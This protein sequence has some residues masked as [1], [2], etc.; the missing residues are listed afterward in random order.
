MIRIIPR[1]DIKGPNLVKG[2]QF[3]GHRV[4]GVAW[5]FARRYYEEGADELFYQDSVA[6]LYRRNGLLDIVRA[7]ASECFIPLT[8]AGG[9]RSIKDIRSLLRAGAD[10]VAINTAA[11]ER[12]EFIREAALEFGSQCIVSSIEAYLHNG[13]YRVWVNYGR[14]RTDLDVFDWAKRVVEAGAGEIYLSSIN[15]DGLGRG[16]DLELIRRVATQVPVPVIASGGAGRAEDLL[17]AIASGCADAVS[18]A[19]LFHYYYA[20]PIDS[21]TM[22]FREERLRMGEAT[23]SGN[24]D[25]L[26]SGYGGVRAVFVEP[27]SLADAKRALAERGLPVRLDANV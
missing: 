23:D 18:A 11:V 2:L 24:V 16:F 14:D 3:E 4:L 7:T 22:T 5:E 9:I 20:K 26:N 21:P 19:S 1:L 27:T 8:V 13:S 10:K 17:S 15:R 12:P 25:F 6:S